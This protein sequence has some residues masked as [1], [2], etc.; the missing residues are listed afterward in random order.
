M[1]NDIS[2]RVTK[3]PDRPFYM[4]RFTDPTTGRRCA[5]STG[6]KHRREAERKAALWEKELR[7]GKYRPVSRISWNDFREKFETEK[8]ASLAKN[9]LD[10]SISAFNHVERIVSPSQ[11]SSLTSAVLSRFQATL[12]EEGMKDTTIATHLRHLRAAL[13]WAVAMEFLA[14]VPKL[15]MPRRPRGQTLMR[16]RP[17]TAG[18]FQHLLSKVVDIRPH[19]TERWKFHLN[20]LWLSGLRLD[21]SLK[22]SWEA[23]SQFAVDFS[24]RHP[25]FRIYAEAE[26]GRQDRLLPMTPDFA[27]FVLAIPYPQ[28]TGFVFKLPGICTGD[29]MT[30]PRAGRVISEIGK[31][32]G[33]LVNKVDGKFA[34][35]HDLR[36]SFGTRWAARVKPA[37]LQ[38]LMRHKSIETTMKY[39]V[40]QDSDD[41]ADELWAAYENVR[42]R[43]NLDAR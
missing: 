28:R 20:G 10:A 13:S 31:L 39:Y 17:I 41:V 30:S 27:E 16:G 40:C 6:T 35:A 29:Q 37:T 36:R 26:K 23:Q 18:E 38:L 42:E 19:D 34:S 21:E 25:R 8:G 24:G 32:A 2:V 1:S 11:L 22:L 14:V 33:I 12:R 7:D 43:T 3:Y 9:T 5:R 4:M 15:H